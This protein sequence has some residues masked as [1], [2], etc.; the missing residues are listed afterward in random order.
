MAERLRLARIGYARRALLE[1]LRVRYTAYRGVGMD[2]VTF[3]PSPAA[4][5]SFD[6]RGGQVERLG[7][8]EAPITAYVAD[9]RH[10]DSDRLERLLS[11]SLIEVG[12]SRLS[13]VSIF[14]RENNTNTKGSKLDALRDAF[15]A[16]P[17][18][19][20]LSETRDGFKLT[21]RD[22]AGFSQRCIALGMDMPID[23]ETCTL[24]PLSDRDRAA[25]HRIFVPDEAGRRAEVRRTTGETDILVKID[26][27]RDAGS[28]IDTGVKFF[29]HMLEQIARHGGI[30]LD[31]VCRGDVDVDAHHTIEDVSL[32]LGEALNRALGERRGIA[33]FGFELPMDET[34]AGAWI[35]LSGR[36]FARFE[37][38]IPGERVGDFPVEM[39]PHV[40]RSLAESLKAAIHISVE[41]ENAHHMIESCFKAFGRA[42][43]QGVVI[44]GGDIPSTKGVL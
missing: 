2:K 19:S 21:L 33:R 25:L 24:A 18:V 16:L 37:G 15:L 23:G 12:L 6:L 1:E 17:E 22:P 10:A 43:R 4:V 32:A 28:A 13:D 14:E 7:P 29:D 40:F 30:C 8:I 38:N 31:V 3:L 42:L 9:V 41:G 5:E 26:L 44:E 11:D 27:D 35:D 34:R 20:G 39:T 36:P